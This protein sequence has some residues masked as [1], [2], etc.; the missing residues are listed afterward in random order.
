MHIDRERNAAEAD[1]RNAEFFLAQKQFPRTWQRRPSLSECSIE[2]DWTRYRGNTQC[3]GEVDYA[4]A[5]IRENRDAIG[6]RFV[7]VQQFVSKC[8]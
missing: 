6:R 4:V 5:G 7:A 2:W 1:E 8:G 3:A